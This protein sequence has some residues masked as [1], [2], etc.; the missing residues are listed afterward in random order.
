M[1]LPININRL[2][3]ASTVESSRIEYK[4][5][6]NPNAIYRT[7]CAFANITLFHSQNEGINEG[8]ND[9]LITQQ[10]Y[11]ILDLINQN[12]RITTSELAQQLKYST[13]TIQRYIKQL[14]DLNLLLKEGS[15]KS[16]IWLIN[17]K[18]PHQIK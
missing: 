17:K 1:T 15:D 12:S 5:G 2:L 9:V 4:K 18:M 8:L 6:W 16:G 3:G 13:R 11:M 10:Q 14:K 7:I